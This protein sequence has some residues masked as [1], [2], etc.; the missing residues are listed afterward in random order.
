[1]NENDVFEIEIFNPSNFSSKF[2]LK[3]TTWGKCKRNEILENIDSGKVRLECFY[4]QKNQCQCFKCLMTNPSLE[5]T[6][7]RE[8]MQEA[9]E[10]EMI[11]ENLNS[12]MK[13]ACEHYC[14]YYEKAVADESV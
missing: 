13:H 8:E 4:D 9:F 3:E 10:N 14:E 11:M 12:I 6:I 2:S 5:M 7:T 1:M